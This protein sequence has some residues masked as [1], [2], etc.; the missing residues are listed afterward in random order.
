MAGAAASPVA[1]VDPAIQLQAPPLAKTKDTVEEGVH[2][3]LQQT[4]GKDKSAIEQAQRGTTPSTPA[5]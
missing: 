5:R 4:G 3:L 1:R 2:Q